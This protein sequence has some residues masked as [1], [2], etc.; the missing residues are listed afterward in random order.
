[1]GVFHPDDFRN[2]PVDSSGPSPSFSTTHLILMTNIC[3]AKATS[4]NMGNSRSVRRCGRKPE[5]I[6][7]EHWIHSSLTIPFLAGGLLQTQ[8]QTHSKRS[9]LFWIGIKKISRFYISVLTFLQLNA[10]MFAINERHSFPTHPS[11]MDYTAT[12]SVKTLS[13]A[14]ASLHHRHMW[15]ITG[16]AGCGKSTIAQYLAK[17]LSIPYIEGDDVSG[18]SSFRCL[19]VIPG[20][21]DH[22]STVSS[23]LQ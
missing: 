13:G 1:M 6:Q 14:L 10:T 2:M 9:S 4:Y 19:H 18:F 22:L 3:S 20:W 21:L 8:M 17:E 7:N 11:P 16:P 15:I 12:A 5:Q 23:R